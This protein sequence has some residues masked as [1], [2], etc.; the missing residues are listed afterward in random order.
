M[1]P[2]TPDVVVFGQLARDL[3]LVVDIPSAIAAY[4]EF[5]KRS[6]GWTKVTLEVA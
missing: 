6:P 2:V 3:V 1:T 4:E 5:D